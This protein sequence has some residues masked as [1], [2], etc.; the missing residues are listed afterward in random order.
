MIDIEN[1][2]IFRETISKSFSALVQ[3]AVRQGW[4]EHD[5]ALLL[6]ELAEDHLMQVGA[7]IIADGALLAHR[8]QDNRKN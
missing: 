4:A 2:E 6:M 8:A 1:A 7:G 5:V 3:N